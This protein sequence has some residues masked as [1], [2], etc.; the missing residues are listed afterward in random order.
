MKQSPW[1]FPSPQWLVWTEPQRHQAAAGL[2]RQ[3]CHDASCRMERLLSKVEQ[4]ESLDT[5]STSIQLGDAR[6]E[7]QL[8]MRGIEGIQKLCEQEWDDS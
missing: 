1:S 8:S 4:G 5:R 6:D 3:N 2:M 7:L